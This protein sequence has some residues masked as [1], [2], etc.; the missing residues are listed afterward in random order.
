MLSYCGAGGYP[1]PPQ[2]PRV[3][4]PG[5]LSPRLSSG[6]QENAGLEEPGARAGTGSTGQWE[7]R[8]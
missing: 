8:G 3:S 6:P 2:D 5:C 4:A 7:G 1:R